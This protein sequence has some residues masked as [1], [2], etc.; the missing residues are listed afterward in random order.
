MRRETYSL[1]SIAEDLEYL[2]DAWQDG[3]TDADLRRGAA[4]L[5]RFLVD[6]GNGVIPIVWRELG[7]EGQ[8]IV[9]APS[10]AS[11]VIEGRE[12]VILATAGGAT[13]SGIDIGGYLRM[14]TP[15]D[16]D[17]NPDGQEQGLLNYISAPCIIVHGYVLTRR[18]LVTYFA[19]YL[20]GVHVSRKIL[21]KQ[22]ERGDRSPFQTNRGPAGTNASRWERS[23]TF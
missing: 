22:E 12:R 1:H 9:M 6:G 4:I 14:T 17:F 7:F 8:P 23:P 13:V 19:N 11:A 20:G 5:R 3:A 21:K 2:R 15:F 18:Q 16:D 10:M